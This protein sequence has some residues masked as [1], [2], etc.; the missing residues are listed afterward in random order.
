MKEKTNIKKTT[1]LFDG[2]MRKTFVKGIFQDLKGYFE[3]MSNGNVEIEYEDF[4]LKQHEFG[5]KLML[6][7]G[8]KCTKQMFNEVSA[9]LIN[10]VNYMF[11]GNNEDYDVSIFNDGFKVEIEFVSNW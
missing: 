8:V 3:M 5:F 11:K 10:V 9:A 7:K 1:I 4:N 2:K 6:S